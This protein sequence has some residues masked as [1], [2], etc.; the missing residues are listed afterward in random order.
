M[1]KCIGGAFNLRT[2]DEPTAKMEETEHFYLNKR[3]SSGV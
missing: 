2:P 1:M 3:K